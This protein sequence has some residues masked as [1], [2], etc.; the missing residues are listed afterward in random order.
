MRT[1]ANLDWQWCQIHQTARVPFMKIL[2]RKV[3]ALCCL[4]SA[5]S[6]VNKWDIVLTANLIS[7]C[8]SYWT[9]NI[10]TNN[11]MAWVDKHNAHAWHIWPIL[12]GHWWQQLWISRMPCFRYFNKLKNGSLNP[13]YLIVSREQQIV[14][15]GELLM[16]SLGLDSASTNRYFNISSSDFLLLIDKSNIK[17]KKDGGRLRVIPAGETYLLDSTLSFSAD[18]FFF[19]QE[20][21]YV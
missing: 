9:M 19:L 4:L 15:G 14:E 12:G 8:N 13:G 1:E 2:S 6:T 10:V 7:T 3:C 5:L 20:S 16:R 17:M 21:G 18:S 11:Q